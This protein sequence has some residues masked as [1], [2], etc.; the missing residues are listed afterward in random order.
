MKEYCNLTHASG[1]LWG[2]LLLPRFFEG[3]LASGGMFNV[4]KPARYLHEQ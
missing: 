2:G 1:G 3:P 4:E